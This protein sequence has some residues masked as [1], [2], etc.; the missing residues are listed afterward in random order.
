MKTIRMEVNGHEVTQSS[1]VSD[2]QPVQNILSLMESSIRKLQY[3]NSD[4]YGLQKLDPKKSLKAL[5][6]QTY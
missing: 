4:I 6:L 1:L 3:A 5:P 2:M